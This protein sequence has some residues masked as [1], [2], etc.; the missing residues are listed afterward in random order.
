MNLRPTLSVPL[1]WL[2]VFIGKTFGKDG[3]RGWRALL[4]P[5]RTLKI[6]REGKWYIGILLLIGIAAINT[7]NNLLYLVVAML[8]SLI[9][10]SGVISEH[11][12]RRVSIERTWPKHIFKGSPALARIAITNLKRRFSTFSISVKEL[13]VPECD[14][15]AV[16]LLKIDNN[17]TV[18]KTATYTFKR[19]GRFSLA[20]VKV[21]TRFPFGLFLKGKEER[22]PDE[23]IVYPDVSHARLKQH[24]DIDGASSDGTRPVGKGSGS[25][26]YGLREYTLNDPARFIYWRAAA[27]SSKLLV[28]EFERESIKKVTIIFDNY[29]PTNEAAFEPVVDEAAAT[30]DWFI[31]RGYAVGMKTLTTEIKPAAGAGQLHRILRT[32]AL[33]EPAATKGRPCVRVRQS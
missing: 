1:P 28:R 10:V 4:K 9:V 29:T 18:V 14:A 23:V 21:S 11:T 30:A 26:L 7:G 27:R 20:G 16:Y 12:L 31:E 19:R 24:T 8:L 15:D 22:C 17:E 25:E 6:T 5:L 32:L 2:T 13:P 3:R 33:I